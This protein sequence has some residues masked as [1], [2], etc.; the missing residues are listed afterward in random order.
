MQKKNNIYEIFLFIYFCFFLNCQK[1]DYYTQKIPVE[2]GYK[3]LLYK[4]GT[5]D[6]LLKES[7]FLKESHTPFFLHHTKEYN[8]EDS[9]IRLNYYQPL[10]DPVLQ[11]AEFFVTMRTEFKKEHALVKP[12][13]AS[14]TTY[15]NSEKVDAD[16][17]YRLQTGDLYAYT[18]R[19]TIGDAL[20]RIYFYE[21]GRIEE[22][23]FA[24]ALDCPITKVK[25]LDTLNVL[26][27][28]VNNMKG[29][30]FDIE[31]IYQSPP[32]VKEEVLLYKEEITPYRTLCKYVFPKI[33]S[34]IIESDGYLMKS[35]SLI[36]K[37]RCGCKI[38]VIK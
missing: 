23:G 19:D 9:L 28:H 7:V 15:D 24:T 4:R 8:Y 12:D 13:I 3:E 14:Y 1:S 38:D 27:Y 2:D 30:N 33:G 32:N 34:Y 16:I 29:Y 5:I 22:T 36:K 31:Y 25:T 18:L 37:Y 6:T 10:S 11:G 17:L 21:D 20:F 26:N 35:D